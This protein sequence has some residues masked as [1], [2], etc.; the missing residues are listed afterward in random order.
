M[1]KGIK[2]APEVKT[3]E[4]RTIALETLRSPHF[5]AQMRGAMREVG[6]AGE[7]TL[8]MGVFLVA[9]SRFRP[10][11]LRLLIQE[12][13]EGTA[14]YIVRKVS[15][16]LPPGSIVS[17]TT[18]DAEGWR[19]FV[20]DPQQKL[21]WVPEW[22][23]WG[24]GGRPHFEIGKNQLARVTPVKRD[25]RTIENREEIEGGFACISA[26][27]P[28]EQN[29]QSRWLTLRLPRKAGADPDQER[30]ILPRG[31]AQVEAWHEVQRQL[32]ERAH[33]PIV[34][35]DWG[36][37]VVE[38]MCGDERVSRHIPALLQVWKTI[39]LLRSFQHRYDE[40]AGILQARFE[41]FAAAYLLARKAFWE[42]QWFPSPRGVF[43]KISPAIQ[44]AALMN[45]V[46]GKGIK[47]QRQEQS[48]MH[49]KTLLPED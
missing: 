24:N 45:P 27:A 33:V 3:K 21:V 43:E 41:D 20:N 16:F 49:W 25:E 14:S 47:Y 5:F 35:P 2:N 32:Q 37:V 10:N 7:E 28:P 6:L 23:H 30:H 36:D 13:T 46:T 1:K 19:R 11:P 8:G 17:L 15:Q 34:L 9:A 40:R 4:V 31:G 18:G 12:R 22:N 29:E 38:P 39:A 48:G 44:N 26:E 42:G